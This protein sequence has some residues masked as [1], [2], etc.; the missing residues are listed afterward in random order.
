MSVN[1]RNNFRGITDY[2]N[3]S[4]QNGP[5]MALSK[6]NAPNEF[7]YD[8]NLQRS[9]EQNRSNS[10]PVHY[11]S[12]NQNL[13]TSPEQNHSNLKPVQQDPDYLQKLN[14]LEYYKNSH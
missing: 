5:H 11:D 1:D 7:N 12:Y 8:Q 4:S 13:Q 2:G 6:F 14:D 10:R 3:I 9:P